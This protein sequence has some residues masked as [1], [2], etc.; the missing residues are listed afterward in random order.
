MTYLFLFF[1]NGFS[2]IFS[3][4]SSPVVER[5]SMYCVPEPKGEKG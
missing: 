4:F 3:F 5:V 1:H 2:I